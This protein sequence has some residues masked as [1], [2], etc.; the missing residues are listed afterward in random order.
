[1]FDI[2]DVAAPWEIAYF[3][4]GGD[5]TR[6]PASW[7]GTTSGYTSAQPRIIAERGEIWFTDQDRGFYV[8]RFTNGAWPF[9]AP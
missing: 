1:V 8:V 4:P 9:G 5:G 6:S 7:G 3:N 2:R